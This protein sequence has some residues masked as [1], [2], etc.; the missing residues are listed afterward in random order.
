MENNHISAYDEE[1]HK[2]LVRHVLIRYGFKT[3]E[4]MVCLVINGEKLPHA[5]KLV[6]KLCEISGMTSI[7]IS[8]NK[9]KTNVIMGNE[10]KL[11]WGQTYITGLYWKCKI[12]DF[13]AFILPG[14]SG[15]N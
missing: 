12:S 7:T 1:K 10:I 3:D 15:T 13:P 2:G 8:V 11:L 9:A 14:Q 6:D 5:E 4:I